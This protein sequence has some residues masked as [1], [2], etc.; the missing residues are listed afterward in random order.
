MNKIFA[1]M[2]KQMNPS[3]KAENELYA[4]LNAEAETKV[5]SFTVWKAGGAAALVCAA[6]AIAVVMIPKTPS[7][8]ITT[9]GG[10]EETAQETLGADAGNN[11]ETAIADIGEIGNVDGSEIY[12]ELRS[13]GEW[14]DY[15]KESYNDSGINAED[16]RLGEKLGRADLAEWSEDGSV[17]SETQT[18]AYALS[19]IAPECAVAVKANI[20]GKAVNRVFVNNSYEPKTLGDLVNDLGLAENLSFVWYY[21]ET[22]ASLKKYKLD[23][24][25]ELFGLIFCDDNAENLGEAHYG[26]RFNADLSVDL[27][28]LNI[29]NMSL[30]IGGDGYIRT[31]L[32]G[33]A[34]SFFIGE[35][36]AAAALDFLA[37]NST[38]AS[39][40]IIGGGSSD[41]NAI[42]GAQTDSDGDNS[43]EQTVIAYTSSGAAP[44]P[45]ENANASDLD[46]SSYSF[47]GAA[48]ELSEAFTPLETIPE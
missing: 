48:E 3:E 22:D 20:G 9:G 6:A 2:K 10:G 35:A 8:D 36:N 27:P 7:T 37:K 29:S 44:T 34:K 30:G 39:E 31:N 12:Y 21:E 42:E 4:K 26:G 24:A 32:L 23:N 11:A 1:D 15:Q 28:L 47:G 43:A 38:L 5:R 40:E 46:G 17:N 25:A 14:A 16:G 18:E 41:I 13:Y 33:T 45:S 19:G